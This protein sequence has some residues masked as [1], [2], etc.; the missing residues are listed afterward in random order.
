MDCIL[1]N[2]ALYICYNLAWSSTPNEPIDPILY[3]DESIPQQ[4]ETINPGSIL[5]SV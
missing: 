2:I 3:Y 1:H 5:K 4:F